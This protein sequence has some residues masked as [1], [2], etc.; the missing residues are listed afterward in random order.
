MLFVFV[1]YYTYNA[2]S[3]EPLK[4]ARRAETGAND[5]GLAGSL[6]K[7]VS[8]VAVVVPRS[9][10]IFSSTASFPS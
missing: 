7:L 3:H 2:K 6:V 1:T 8:C 10:S 9:S 5:A 4:T